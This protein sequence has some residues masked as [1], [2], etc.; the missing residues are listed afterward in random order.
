MGDAA[1]VRNRAKIL[2][3]RT[4]AAA[5]LALR[6]EGGLDALVWSHRPPTTPEPQ[7][8]ADVP[9][10]SEGSVALS[11]DLRRHGFSFVGPT[12]AYALMEAVGMVDTHLVGCHRRG[13]SGQ[14]PA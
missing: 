13:C 14:F 2:A 3:A 7:T 5:T 9:T 12:T 11:K 10:R 8:T 6:E 1:I 4:N